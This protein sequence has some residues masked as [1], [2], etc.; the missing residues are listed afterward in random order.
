MT[1]DE[2]ME[3]LEM[4]LSDYGNDVEEATEKAADRC[5]KQVKKEIIEHCKFGGSGEYIKAFRI[6]K[7]NESYGIPKGKKAKKRWLGRRW[8]VKAPHYRKTHLLENG[9]ATRKGGR[10]RA[11]P[12]IKYGE[13]FALNNY[14]NFVKEEV[15]KIA[16]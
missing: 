4:S 2:F 16:T 15:E 3:E 14:E 5:A 13:E 1:A 6:M 7:L 11:F 12:H 10:T 9:H 8:Y